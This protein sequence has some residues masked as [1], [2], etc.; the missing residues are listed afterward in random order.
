MPQVKVGVK[1]Y[2]VSLD[3]S[4]T[5]AEDATVPA[6][7]LSPTDAFR[8]GYTA[9]GIVYKSH[10]G[11]NVLTDLGVKDL[12]AVQVLYSVAA[13]KPDNPSNPGNEPAQPAQLGKD[14][15]AEPGKDKPAQPGKDQP[16]QPGEGKPAQSGKAVQPSKATSR[17]PVVVAASRLGDTG[18]DASM[19]ALAAL[20]LVAAG[21]SLTFLSRI[22]THE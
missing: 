16:A 5:W 12:P 18:A 21:C 1:G 19:I 22:H 7:K 3:G 9:Q 8:F 11:K 2:E 10:D 14:K 17:K 15:P 20:L 6:V 4:K 13:S